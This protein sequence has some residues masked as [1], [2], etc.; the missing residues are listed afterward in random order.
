MD[1][2]VIMIKLLYKNIS[3]KIANQLF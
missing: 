2:V 1:Q 3:L